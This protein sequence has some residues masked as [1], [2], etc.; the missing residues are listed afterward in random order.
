MTVGMISPSY[1]PVPPKGYGGTE[2]C[3]FYFVKGLLELGHEVILFAP[4]DSEVECE[5]IP[6]CERSIPIG[7]SLE[8]EKENQKERSKA[9]DN[10]VNLV[11]KNLARIDILHSHSSKQ[12]DVSV[13]GNF[14]SLTTVHYPFFMGIN[15]DAFFMNKDKLIFNSISDNQQLPMPMLNW[16]GT[17]YNGLDPNDFPFVE[18]PD[19]YLCFVG[20]FDT[21]KNPHAAIHAA[22]RVGIELRMAGS[23]NVYASGYFKKEC[24]PY[25]DGSTV[26]YLGELGLK[27]KADLIAH[28][29]ANLHPISFREPFGLTVLESGYCGTPTVATRRG[30]MPELIKNGKTGVIV[31]DFDEMPYSIEKAFGLDRKFVANEFRRRFSYKIMAEQTLL[32]YQ[33]IIDIYDKGINKDPEKL[34]SSMMMTSEKLRAKYEEAVLR[35]YFQ[36]Q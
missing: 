27:A 33:L 7:K 2:R 5:L 32:A 8:E 13:F 23:A 21:D 35:N 6:I 34:K 30:S 31:E 12:V 17:I 28:A 20:R 9:S 14:P 16:I 26:K 22:K 25:I 3:V 24:E 36:V 1:L 29:R 11:K 4:G 10:L 18:T 15:T 19:D